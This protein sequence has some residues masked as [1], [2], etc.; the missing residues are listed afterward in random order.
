ML[1][2]KNERGLN[3]HVSVV[4]GIAIMLMLLG[5]SGM[6]WCG[7]MLSMIRMPV[8]VIASGYCFKDYYITHRL[9]FARRRVKSLYWPFVKWG[10]LFVLLHN[11]FCYMGLYAAETPVYGW[12]DMAQ[13]VPKVLV[14]QTPEPLVGGI[15]FITELFFG[16]ML[17]TLLL[18]LIKRCPLAWVVGFAAVAVLMN[19]TGFHFRLRDVSLMSASYYTLGYWVRG[20]TLSHSWRTIAVLAV[21]LYLSSLV[22]RGNFQHMAP[23]WIVP[24]YATV[25]VGAWL[26]AALA[27]HIVEHCPLL[28][29]IMA[30]VGTHTLIILTLHFLAMRM[31]SWLIIM[32]TGMPMECLSHHPVIKGCVWAWPLYFVAGLTLPLAYDWLKQKTLKTVGKWLKNEREVA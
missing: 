13:L 32:C 30:H 29:R 3:D 21:T 20:R 1:L 7:H 14:M 15:W 12:R 18:P 11:V 24:N 10:L 5:H 17:F 22:V 26:L 19:L 8:F 2:R 23:A 16:V 25:I 31:V 28:T 6:P 4:K 9:I 27:W